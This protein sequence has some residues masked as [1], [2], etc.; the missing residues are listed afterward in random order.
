[1][2]A[3]SPGMTVPPLGATNQTNHQTGALLLF[4]GRYSAAP[5]SGSSGRA[6]LGMRAASPGMTVPP[7]GATNQTNHETG[8]LLLFT[9]EGLGMRAAS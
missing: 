9:G 8:T 3:A 7:L 4:T 5:R 2:R 6:G 1:M